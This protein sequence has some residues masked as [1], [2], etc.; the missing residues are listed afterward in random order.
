MRQGKGTNEEGKFT[1]LLLRALRLYGREARAR[2]KY[3]FGVC[4]DIFLL[5]G[6]SGV[7]SRVA[8]IFSGQNMCQRALGG[9][10]AEAAGG[11]GLYNEAVG[12]YEVPRVLPS[13][14]E[15]LRR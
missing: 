8:G 4:D 2:G 15:I 12:R 7:L 3:A 11:A 1:R 14:G 5:E 6:R 10:G 13:G 9:Q